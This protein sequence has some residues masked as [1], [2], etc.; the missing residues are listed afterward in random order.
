MLP[1]QDANT[2]V[3]AVLRGDKRRKSVADYNSESMIAYSDVDN[4]GLEPTMTDAI[5]R[6]PHM[7]KSMD[8]YIHAVGE[9]DINVSSCD[10]I[11]LNTAKF[12]NKRAEEIKWKTLLIDNRYILKV[13]IDEVYPYS[14]KIADKGEIAGAITNKK[15][16]LCYLAGNYIFDV[17]TGD[18]LHTS[19]ESSTE[20]KLTKAFFKE[21]IGNINK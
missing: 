14:Y 5:Y 4:L 17:Q 16:G 8:A 18:V 13:G 20:K 2:L 10:K 7:I 9:G 1:V 6:L 21:L 12:Y 15:S 11:R 3:I 19:K